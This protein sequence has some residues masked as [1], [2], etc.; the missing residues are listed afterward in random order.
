MRKLDEEQKSS[1]DEKLEELLKKK[2]KERTRAQVFCVCCA[3]KN[4]TLYKWH[5]SYLCKDCHDSAVALGDKLFIKI[6]FEKKED[7]NGEC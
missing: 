5:N 2:Q 1:I 6:Y 4:K 3:A 7:A